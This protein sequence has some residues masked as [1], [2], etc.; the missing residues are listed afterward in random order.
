MHRHE[1]PCFAALSEHVL[2]AFNI[3]RRNRNLKSRVE[4]LNHML[5]P[6]CKH[7]TISNWNPRCMT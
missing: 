6:S 1:V 3:S 5:A 7:G 4:V 2:M